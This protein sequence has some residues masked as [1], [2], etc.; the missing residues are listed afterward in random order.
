MPSRKSKMAAAGFAL[1]PIAL[2]HACVVAFRSRARWV[3]SLRVGAVRARSIASATRDSHE[4]ARGI[5]GKSAAE[6]WL[7]RAD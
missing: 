4:R 7:G 6:A 3:Q 1:V 2:C 5:Q